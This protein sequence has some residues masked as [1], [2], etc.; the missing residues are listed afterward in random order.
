MLAIFLSSR[1]QPKLYLFQMDSSLFESDIATRRTFQSAQVLTMILHAFS[2]LLILSHGITHVAAQGS[3]QNSLRGLQDASRRLANDLPWSGPALD[4]GV[5]GLTQTLPPI[6]TTGA[7]T[8]LISVDL[9]IQGALE[10]AA[11]SQQDTLK[12]YYK[13]DTNPEVLW[14]A[15]VGGNFLAQESVTVPAGNQLTLRVDGKTSHS[16]EIYFLRNFQVTTG[17]DPEPSP[18]AAPVSI[19]VAAPV[20][21]P[22]PTPVSIPV[23]APVPAPVPTPPVAPSPQVCGVPK[24]SK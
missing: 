6:D 8:V 2:T 23:A 4:I 20:S 15:I 7:A 24:V 5:A 11:G 16:S 18:V 14:K 10:A 13:V 1:K 19:P 12:I 22:V 3:G 9:S 17:G 21:T